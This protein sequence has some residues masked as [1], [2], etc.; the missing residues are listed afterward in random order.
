MDQFSL[1]EDKSNRKSKVEA[2]PRP[3]EGA[4]PGFRKSIRIGIKVMEG[5]I[6]VIASPA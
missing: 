2:N 6:I 1:E 3:R 5:P 4:G